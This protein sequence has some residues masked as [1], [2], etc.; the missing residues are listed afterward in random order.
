MNYWIRKAKIIALS[1]AL[2]TGLASQYANGQDANSPVVTAASDD[3]VRIL[4]RGEP[5]VSVLH[6]LETLTGRSVIRPQALPTP[7]FTFDSRGDMTL[8]ESILAIESLLSINGIGV[9][10]LGDKFL[11]VVAINTIR[12]EAPE[13]ETETL[14]DR[15]PSGKV[16]S[17]LFRLQYLDSQTF[18]SQIQPFLSPGF[19]TIIPFQN[20]NAVIVTD[21]ISNLQ[22]LEYVVSEVDKPSRLNVKTQFYT[23]QYAQAS[24]VAEQIQGLIDAARANFGEQPGSGNNANNRAQN[25]GTRESPDQPTRPTVVA[26][27]AGEG[28]IPSQILFGSNTAIASDDRTNQIIIMTEPSNIVFFDEII[29]KLDIK[30]D[31]ATRI[32]VIILNHAQATEVAGLLSSF[33]SGST[34]TETGDRSQANANQNNPQQNQRG[35]QSVNQNARQNSQNQSLPPQVRNAVTA[36]LEDRDSQFSEFMT[37]E[38]DERSNSLI[39]SGTRSDLDLMIELVGKIDVLLPQVR[40]EVIIAEV[41]LDN[42]TDRGMDQVGGTYIQNEAAGEPN[43]TIG[44][45][46]FP[47]LNLLGIG[48]GNI[49]M[50]YDKTAGVLSNLSFEAI[51]NAARTNSNVEILSTPYLMTTHNQEATV[52]VGQQRPIVTGTLTDNTLG[53]STRQTVQYQ[54]IAIELKVKPLI[55]PNDVIQLEID[56]SVNDIDGSVDVNGNSQPIIGR[57]QMVSFVSVKNN[58]LV[59][60]GGMQRS[61]ETK[62]KNRMALLGEI[63]L[64]GNLFRSNKVDFE[65][66]ELLVFIRPKIIRDADEADVDA[67]QAIQDHTMSGTLDSSLESGH[68]DLRKKAKKGSSSKDEESK[69]SVSRKPFKR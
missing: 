13:L 38:A 24:E 45:G 54:D 64:L 15:A 66:R 65:K 49:S 11:K 17:K 55:G 59:V 6:S 18:Q 25:S 37:I 33:V 10:P 56:Q 21:T 29:E 69:D 31:P 34:S 20:S 67:Q 14:K 41:N 39:I 12:T 4:W 51:L 52:T 48:V 8:E 60:L 47:G 46:D 68:F 28:A 63:P 5:L 16:V 7:E 2:I 27:S 30:S 57:R 35:N 43:I 9:T 61:K 26:A 32:E 42:G 53:N 36:T 22:R 3:P 1:I 23:L 40:I 62:S 50:N 44:T 19:S 58:G